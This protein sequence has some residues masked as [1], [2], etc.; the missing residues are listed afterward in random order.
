MGA[1]VTDMDEIKRSLTK[2]DVKVDSIATSLANVQLQHGEEIS[3][4]QRSLADTRERANQSF[5]DGQGTDLKLASEIGQLKAGLDAQMVALNKAGEGRSQQTLVILM[6][7]L[8]LL[9]L[10]IIVG[11]FVVRGELKA[12][13]YATTI[14]GVVMALGGLVGFAKMS[15]KQRVE[16]TGKSIRPPAK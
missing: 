6:G 2:L 9:A 12:E 10:L 11:V 3:R 15:A 7:G 13:Q 5:A 8:I 16:T 1:I 4:L 14:G